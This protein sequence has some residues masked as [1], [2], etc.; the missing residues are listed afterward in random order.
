MRFLL[1]K[2][3]GGWKSV[4][5]KGNTLNNPSIFP[6]LGLQYLGSVL[7][8]EGHKVEIID[9]GAQIVT[10]EQLS[11]SLILSDAVGMSVCSNDYT[12]VAEISKKISE[13]D[14][15]IVQMI[16]GPHCTFH[17]EKSLN[18]IPDA[19][20]CCEGE[21]EIVIK[22]IVRLIQGRKD[23][24]IIHGIHY[25]ENNKIKSGKPLEVI[26]DLDSIPFPARHLLDKYEYGKFLGCYPFKRKFTVMISS[27]GCPFHCRFCARYGN[28]VDSYGF[29]KRSAENVVEEI[30][31]IAKK[32][33]S[34]MM[35][36]DN[37]LADVKRA[38][39]ILDTLIDCDSSID[40]LIMGTRVDSAERNL[41]VKMKKAG[42]KYLGFGIE[43]G[44]QDILNFYNKKIT[45]QQIRKAVNLG[46]EMGFRTLGTFMIGAP[47]ETR[48]H[49][50]NTIKFACSLPL[51]VAIFGSLKYE[52]G[53]DMWN[54]A[55]KNKSISEDEFLVTADSRR[56]LGNFTPDEL[57]SFNELAFRRFYIRPFFILKKLYKAFLRK[58]FGLVN[59][60]I[61]YMI[62]S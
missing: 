52:M 44:N 5:A 20:I 9:F 23:P 19:D 1:L 42:V 4:G 25:R 2:I 32:Y 15:D 14:P 36:D 6:P 17:K 24:S 10:N 12:A 11:N 38:H 28:V 58:D 41:Y 22:D 39:K 37:F 7:E 27:R 49:I 31:E 59:R 34:V 60:G 55:V 18:H 29:R 61:H 48:E 16:G 30:I 45:L 53:S 57:Q 40:L 54:E 47:I 33:G 21:G 46:S 50:E 3:S 35:C 13:I 62:N 8:G 26:K 56:G 51:D 43:S